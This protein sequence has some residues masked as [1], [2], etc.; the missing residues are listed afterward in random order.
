MYTAWRAAGKILLPR[1]VE[2]GIGELLQFPSL[3]IINN[4]KNA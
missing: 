1:F 3:S 2:T 4:P